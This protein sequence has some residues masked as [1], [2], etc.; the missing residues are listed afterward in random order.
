MATSLNTE[1]T[2]LEVAKTIPTI[3]HTFVASADSRAA[4]DISTVIDITRLSAL[5]KLLRVT[6]LVLKFVDHLCRKRG[7]MHSPKLTA[8]DIGR[9]E[10]MWVK[11]VQRSSFESELQSLRG[12]IVDTPL[13]KQ[14][15][16]FLDKEGIIRCQGRIDHS[17][18]LEG[19]KTPIL[20]PTRHYFTELLIMHRQNQVFHDGIREML[21]L[22]RETHWI[23]R[24]R[25]AVKRILRK[26]VVC[27]RYEG[28]AVPS[29]PV[30]QLPK[31]RV[32]DHPPFAVTG[33]D[34][35]GISGSR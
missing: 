3:V 7:D 20:M 2:N 32:G 27:R 4:V 14:L 6:A 35:A 5:M 21:N 12:Q 15:N 34:F 23:R 22:I 29:P 11:S 19:S 26:C 13:Q 10:T 31:D 30:P 1:D 9:A 16:L 25:E 17:T 18:V 33:V 8:T 24:G 28:K